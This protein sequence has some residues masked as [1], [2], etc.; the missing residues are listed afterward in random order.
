M[1]DLEKWW[2]WYLEWGFEPT[3]DAYEENIN[4]TLEQGTPNMTGYSGFVFITEFTLD[5]EFV[6]G[7]AYE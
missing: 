1:T 3:V 6:G 4:I 5:C 2:W 7:G